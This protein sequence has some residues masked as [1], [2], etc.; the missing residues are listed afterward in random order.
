MQPVVLCCGIWRQVNQ[1]VLNFKGRAAIAG[2][3]MQEAVV[4]L[5]KAVGDGRIKL[6]KLG[7]KE[8]V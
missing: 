3:S 8:D 2:L 4:L 1:V 7:K 5:L 6:E